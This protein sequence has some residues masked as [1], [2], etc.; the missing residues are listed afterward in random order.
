MWNCTFSWMALSFAF[1]ASRLTFLNLCNDEMSSLTSHVQKWQLGNRTKLASIF[2][3][4]ITT[5]SSPRLKRA[6]ED[7]T[8]V[9]DF[10]KINKSSEMHPIYKV[11]MDC[12]Y[13]CIFFIITCNNYINGTFLFV[14]VCRFQQ[15]KNPEVQK[16]RTAD[17]Q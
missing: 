6:F 12:I 11:C 14:E 4:G 9:C 10:T 3:M 8:I 15:N 1:V 16:I 2:T 5:Y 7:V 17:I 13:Y